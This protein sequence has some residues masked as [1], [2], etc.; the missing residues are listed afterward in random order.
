ML[1][2]LLRNDCVT[3]NEWIEH[4]YRQYL[5]YCN[6]KIYI[7]FNSFSLITVLSWFFQWFEYFRLFVMKLYNVFS[8]NLITRIRRK[9]WIF[10][11][12][13]NNSNN[14]MWKYH[15]TLFVACL[16]RELEGEQSSSETICL[17]WQFEGR[18]YC[19]HDFQMLFAPCCHQCGEFIF[20][21]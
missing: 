11:T 5:F 20:L 10:S 9:I 7:L 1:E 17:F 18:K 2:I 8:V 15:V 4:I 6:C 14:L 12:L 3:R 21:L 13:L 16:W 19:E